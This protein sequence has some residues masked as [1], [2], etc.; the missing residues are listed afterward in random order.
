[1]K[2]PPS[3]VP[4]STRARTKGPA[5][6]KKAKDGGSFEDVL[7]LAQNL[8]PPVHSPAPPPMTAHPQQPKQRSAQT[9]LAKP[10]RN[11]PTPGQSP[12]AQ[13]PGAHTA[14]FAQL[15]NDAARPA[16]APGVSQT[17]SLARAPMLSELSLA[18]PSLRITGGA[19]VMRMSLQ[20]ATSGSLELEVR[21]HQGTTDVRFDGAAHGLFV[22]RAPELERVLAAEGLAL[23]T[24]T[25]GGERNPD[26]EPPQPPDQR[27]RPPLA[28][29]RHAPSVSNSSLAAR[30]DGRIDVQA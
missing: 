18:D 17:A 23:G 13:A 26:Q 21:V 16:A 20:T 22:E 6:A 14:A 24:Y 27:T 19:E 29:N 11:A 25:T 9:G 5:G 12:R 8:R 15:V 4:V 28:A 7:Q 30:H 2:L 1:M 3:N 10:S